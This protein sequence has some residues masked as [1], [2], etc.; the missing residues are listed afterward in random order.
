MEL[1]HNPVEKEKMAEAMKFRKT[2]AA[3]YNPLDLRALQVNSFPFQKDISFGIHAGLIHRKTK[4]FNPSLQSNL[5]RAD[6]SI[7][8]HELFT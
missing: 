6:L 5:M 1:F 7:L 3:Y 2:M 8:W 4:A